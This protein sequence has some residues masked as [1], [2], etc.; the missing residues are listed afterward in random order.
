MKRFVLIVVVARGHLWH[1]GRSRDA[2]CPAIL[3][4]IACNK[5]CLTQNAESVL[6]EDLE[7]EQAQGWEERLKLLGRGH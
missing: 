5:S 1:L 4:R 7:K 2:E 3:G 6:S